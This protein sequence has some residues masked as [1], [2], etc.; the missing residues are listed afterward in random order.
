MTATLVGAFGLYEK[1]HLLKFIVFFVCFGLFEP[2]FIDFKEPNIEEVLLKTPLNANSTFFFLRVLYFFLWVSFFAIKN[3][4]Y[5]WLRFFLLLNWSSWQKLHLLFVQLIIIRKIKSLKYI[6]LFLK[7]PFFNWL[8]II[9]YVRLGWVLIKQC[10]FNVSF[11]Q[12]SYYCF[13]LYF[14]LNPCFSL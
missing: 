2:I 12:T 10:K 14:L 7:E 11:V 1:W 8:L 3:S 9:F 5:I 4:L 13:N 6:A